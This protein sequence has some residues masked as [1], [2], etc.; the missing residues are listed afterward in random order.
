MLNN[1]H[2]SRNVIKL[3]IEKKFHNFNI[4]CRSEFPSDRSS[5]TASK[6]IIILYVQK[7]PPE[8]FYKK[9]ALRN[10]TRFTGKHLCQRLFFNKAAGLRPGTLLKKR[11]W[12]RCFLVNL[13]KFLRTS[14]YRTPPD[15]C[16]CTFETSFELMEN[17]SI[18]HF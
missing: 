10:L 12:R 11:P 5:K 13:E 17:I 1:L 7:Q 9:A 18:I 2:I 14:F 8:V 4:I 16:F 6:I 3:N 15:D